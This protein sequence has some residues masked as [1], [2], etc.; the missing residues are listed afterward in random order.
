M[1]EYLITIGSPVHWIS[2][3]L[4]VRLQI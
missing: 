4:S 3:F 1:T 2:G